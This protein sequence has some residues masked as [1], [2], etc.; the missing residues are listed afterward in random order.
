M[1]TNPTP[2]QSN[3]RNENQPAKANQQHQK[4]DDK[5]NAPSANPAK[6]SSGSNK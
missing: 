2:N 1:S 6:T 3:N 4:N 5:K